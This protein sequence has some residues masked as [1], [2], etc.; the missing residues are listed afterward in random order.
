MVQEYILNARSIC[1][2]MNSILFEF[3]CFY[4]IIILFCIYISI[5][6]FLVFLLN[7]YLKFLVIIQKS[8]LTI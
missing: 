7:F 8:L 5:N 4:F 3:F 6:I 2:Y 1:F